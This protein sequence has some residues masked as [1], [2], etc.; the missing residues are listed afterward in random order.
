MNII[1]LELEDVLD[2]HQQQL[3][4]FGGTP[5]VLSW[6]MLESAVAT[7]AAGFGETYFHENLYIMAA[8]YLFHLVRNHPFLDGNKRTGAVAAFDFLQINGI[9]LQ[10]EECEFERLVRDAAEGK[11]NKE[12]IAE[13]F[14]QNSV[15]INT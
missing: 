2:I 13:F 6:D 8:A 11:V 15:E 1:F 5:G 7:P 4:I 14:R 3:E 10:A 9:D 12:Q